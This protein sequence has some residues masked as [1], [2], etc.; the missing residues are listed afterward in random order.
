MASFQN[1]ASNLSFDD[2]KIFSSL[3]IFTL[4]NVQKQIA[5]CL[6]DF[7]FHTD[8]IWPNILPPKKKSH[9]LECMIKSCEH[10]SH[11]WTLFLSDWRCFSGL[12]WYI[13]FGILI[14]WTDDL[15]VVFLHVRTWLVHILRIGG[16]N[17]HKSFCACTYAWQEF[18]GFT[19]L[20]VARAGKICISYFWRQ[21]K[22]LL[23]RSEQEVFSF[24]FYFRNQIL[25]SVNITFQISR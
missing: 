10:D 1:S 17:W 4:H 21:K 13:S 12:T 18:A 7:M 14:V 22:N 8:K 19:H 24:G 25:F 6:H 15:L 16:S 5:T 2:C 3:F 20:M 23:L 11:F 9:L